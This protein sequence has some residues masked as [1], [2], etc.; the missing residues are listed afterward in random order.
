VVASATLGLLT[1]LTNFPHCRQNFAP[2]ISA[3]PQ[4]SQVAFDI[5]FANLTMLPALYASINW[6]NQ[7]VRAYAVE[8]A[9]IALNA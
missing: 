6:L 4:F 3:V 8:T 5:S 2:G 1:L 9:A 7:A